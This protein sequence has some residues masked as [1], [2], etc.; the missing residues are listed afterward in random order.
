MTSSYWMLGTLPKTLPLNSLSN[1][2]AYAALR[3]LL[4]GCLCALGLAATAHAQAPTE[5]RRFSGDTYAEAQQRVESARKASEQSESDLRRLDKEF[6]DADAE[7]KSAHKQWDE[8][9]ARLEQAKRRLAEGAKRSVEAKRT[10]DR[11][12]QAFGQLRRATA[13]PPKT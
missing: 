5:E 10:L 12:E 3:L 6:Q 11:E 4:L 9:K 13:K 2:C 1:A 7:M 8:S